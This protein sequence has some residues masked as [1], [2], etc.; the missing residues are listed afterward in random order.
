MYEYAEYLEIK[1]YDA[2]PITI[3]YLKD[4]LTTKCQDIL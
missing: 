4:T 1:Q 2:V 3:R